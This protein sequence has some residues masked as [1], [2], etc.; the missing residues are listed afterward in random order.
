[1][2]EEETGGQLR[3]LTSAAALG[4]DYDGSKSSYLSG[5]TIRL[6]KTP[7]TLSTNKEHL[8]RGLW[9]AP[10]HIRVGGQP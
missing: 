7:T 5:V 4:V 3:Y 6:M 8:R 10:H 9:T 2:E 1:M